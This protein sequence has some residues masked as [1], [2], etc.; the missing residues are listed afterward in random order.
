M[1]SDPFNYLFS[2][3][4]FGIKFGLENIQALVA[5]LDHPEQTFGILHVAGTNGKGSVTAFAERALRSAGYR[6]GRYTSPHLVDLSERFAINGKAVASAVLRAAITR[7]Q[8]LV[9]RLIEGGALRGQP[10]FFEATTA[11]AFDLF[12]EANV[13]V[14]VC[15]VGLGGRLDATNVVAPLVT[16]VTS[17][18][19]DH[20]QYLG[21][22][23]EEIAFEKAG[24][25]KAGVPVV[26]GAMPHQARA[27]IA[28]VA[29]E[30]SAPVIFAA[31]D[32]EAMTDEQGRV[33]LSTPSR[34]YGFVRLG[35]AGAHQVENAR[36]AV[37]LLETAAE[38]G[39]TMELHDI[40]TGLSDVSWPG[41]LDR[42]SMNDGREILLDAAHNTSGVDALVDY[43]KASGWQNLPLVFGAMADK[44]VE[45]ML[46]R[47]LPATGPVILTQAS[48]SRALDARHAAALVRRIDPER[49]VLV[50]EQPREALDV[51]W[52][53]SP[54]IVAAGSIFLIGD[55]LK[56]I[57]RT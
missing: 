14:A 51:A 8:A 11:I 25:V 9:D 35:L 39:L 37:R 3:E 49:S 18:G 50:H 26:I 4:R 5:G 19:F 13:E 6:T 30:R 44:D 43:L 24:I 54:R 57:D 16:A 31:D 32:V 45:G 53:L 22:T 34:D 17:I 46:H 38:R 1:T 36:V 29:A 52:R 42:R 28:A 20:Q 27:T 48:N 2:L 15:E 56:E 12:R 33:R 7:L 40:V 23:L 47:L 21:N 10:T 41:R 55:L